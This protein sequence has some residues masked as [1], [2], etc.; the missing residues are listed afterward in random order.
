MNIQKICVSKDNTA[1]IK[2]PACAN[3]KGVDAARLPAPPRAIKVRCG[4]GEIFQLCLDYRR[5]YRKDTKLL[6]TYTKESGKK[7]RGQ[8]L[9]VDISM[10]GLCFQ[11]LDQHGALKNGD[12][13]LVE[14]TTD[15]PRKVTISRYVTILASSGR[16][17]NCEFLY[18]AR[19][20]PALALFLAP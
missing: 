18:P 7:Y 4:C 20:D 9:L 15:D 16:G 14:F 10:G 11:A 13:L 6:G 8:L 19:T 5:F 17:F 1:R 12:E 2:C 3:C